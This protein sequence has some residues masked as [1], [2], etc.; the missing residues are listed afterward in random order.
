MSCGPLSGDGVMCVNY[1]DVE[2]GDLGGCRIFSQVF[3]HVS[4]QKKF[5]GFHS[6]NPRVLVPHVRE[7]L[8]QGA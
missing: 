2:G 5:K 1:G 7:Y 8:S 3:H 6:V 4:S